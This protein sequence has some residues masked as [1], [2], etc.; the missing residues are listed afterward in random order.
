MELNTIIE[1]CKNNDRKCQEK[2]YKEYFA[3]MMSMC[4]R[5]V[6][7]KYKA[8][9]IVNDG[10]LK[11]FKKIDQYEFRG[12]FEGWMRRIVFHSISDTIR[13]DANYL[14]FMVFE[15]H[16]KKYKNRILDNL[17]EEDLIKMIDDIPPASGDIFILYAIQGYAHKEIAE[18]KNI[19]IGTSKWH[20]SEARKKLQ[21]LVLENYKNSLNAG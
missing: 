8:A 6:Q 2:L 14:K 20:L 3:T 13:K 15:E 16:D 7:D 11:V 10:F 18:M 19:S 4:M 21:N 9:E 12:S 1:G 5:Y 17:Y